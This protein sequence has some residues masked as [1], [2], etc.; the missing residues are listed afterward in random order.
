VFL[1]DDAVKRIELLK[2]YGYPGEAI[3]TLLRQ[4]E[5]YSFETLKEIIEPYKDVITG[6]PN[7]TNTNKVNSEK[8]ESDHYIIQA[9]E[10]GWVPESYASAIVELKEEE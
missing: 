2:D 7:T 10:R 3:P 9:D 6:K 4:T 1:M 8:S 5:K